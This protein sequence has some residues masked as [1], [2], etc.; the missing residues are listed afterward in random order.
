MTGVRRERREQMIDRDRRGGFHSPLGP[1]WIDCHS[2][3][4]PS[5]RLCQGAA[6][7]VWPTCWCTTVRRSGSAET[8]LSAAAI[9]GIEDERLREMIFEFPYPAK[10]R[11]READPCPLSVREVDALRGLAEGK[12]YKQIAQEPCSP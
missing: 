10:E 4:A 2:G 7:A 1:A 8:I 5:R 12:V 6:A 9:L 3:R 11:R